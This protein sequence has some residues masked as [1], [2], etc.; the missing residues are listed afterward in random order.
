MGKGRP[1]GGGCQLA[2]MLKGAARLVQV[3]EPA[4]PSSGGPNPGAQDG[5][6]GLGE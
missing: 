6:E 4:I 5:T 1:N 3:A 2:D